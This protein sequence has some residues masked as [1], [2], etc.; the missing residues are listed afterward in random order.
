[1]LEI[2]DIE[3]FKKDFNSGMIY[4]ELAIKNF[5]SYGTV[6]KWLQKLGLKKYG[7]IT[8]KISDIEE[9]KNDFYNGMKLQELADKHYV[10]PSTIRNWIN[11]LKIYREWVMV[12]RKKV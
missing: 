10:S 4:E 3:Q 2:P 11:T 7:T 12:A 6:C 8:L 1:M 9:F 5:V